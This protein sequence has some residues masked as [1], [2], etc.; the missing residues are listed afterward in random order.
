MKM[1]AEEFDARKEEFSPA[2]HD[3]YWNHDYTEVTIVKLR[4]FSDESYADYQGD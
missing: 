1:T 4:W 2:N 3:F